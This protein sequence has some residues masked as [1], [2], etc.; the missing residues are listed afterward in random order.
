MSVVQSFYQTVQDH[1]KETSTGNV[2]T[3]DK[4]KWSTT[5]WEH[6]IGVEIAIADEKGNGN[7]YFVAPHIKWGRSAALRPDGSLEPPPP[8]YYAN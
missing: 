8:E 1:T 7:M 6:D 5:V 2:T 4:S 3:G